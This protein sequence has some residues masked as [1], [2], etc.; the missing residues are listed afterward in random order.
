MM[1]KEDAVRGRCQVLATSMA[2]AV[3]LALLLPAA[4]GAQFGKNKIQYREFDWKIYHSPHFDVYYYEEEEHLLQKVV[5]FAESAYDHLS[6]EFDYQIKQP[7]P[8]IFYETHSAFEQNNI[9]MNFIPEGIGAFASPVR[10]RMVLPVDLPDPQLMELILHELTH[11]FQYNILCGASAGK[12]VAS[13]PPQWFME[14]M[15]SYMAKDESARDRMYLRD[16]V[17]NDRIPAVTS[18]QVSGFFAYRFGHAVFDFIEEKYGKEAFRDFMV[19]MRNTIG[20]R[21]GRAVERTFRMDP[22]D[23]DGEFRRWLRKKYLPELL[24]TGEPADFGR[25]FRTGRGVGSAELSPAASPSGDLVAAFSTSK[26]DI[27]VVLFDARERELLRN[28][29]KG[30]SA[31]YQ[32]FV[33]QDLAVARRGGHDL[34]FSPDGN[35]LAFFARQDRGRK[36]VLI[37]VLKGKIMRSLPMEVEQQ[38]GLAWSPDGSRIAFGGHQDGRFD[39]FEVDVA[40]GAVANLTSDGVYDQ[41]PTYSP[42]GKSMVFSSV[43]GGYAKLFRIDRANPGERFQLTQGESNETDAIYSPDGTQI[44]FTSDRSGADNI[45]GLELESGQITQYTNSVTGCSQPAVLARPDG[46]EELVYT[47]Y[48]KGRFDL[49]RLDIKDPITEPILIADAAEPD[50]KAIRADEL[51]RFEPTIEVA[52]D[53]A[54]KDKYGGFKLF[55]EDAGGTMGVSDDQTFIAQAY[56]SFTDYLGDKRILGVFQ[57]I[58]S[59]QNFNIIYTDLSR[60]WQWQVHLFD[61]R[62]FFLSRDAFGQIRRG[63]SALSQTGVIASIIYPINTNHRVEV[64][65][66]YQVR[67]ID[68]QSSVAVP[69][70]DFDLPG[71]FE[72]VP[73]LRELEPFFPPGLNDE[74]LLA[75]IGNTFFPSGFVAVP[76]IT[77]REDDYPLIQAAL[78]GDSAVFAPWGGVTGR[79]WRLGFDWAPD[80]ESSGTLTSTLSVDF[81]QYLTLT[82]RSNIAVRFVGLVREGNFATP[83]FFGGLDTLRGFEFRGFFANF[84]LRFPLIDLLATPI[85]NFQ[86]VRALFFL[87]VGGAWFD[88][89]QEFDFWDSE[90]SR[91]G[92]G[93]SSYGFGLSFRLLGV[94]WNFDYAKRWDLKETEDGGYRSSFWI[95]R[96]F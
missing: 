20:A 10:N 58:E 25:P 63:T 3:V 29:T 34:V 94:D 54:S 84:E 67:D 96:R 8:M 35:D 44:Y 6:Q 42:D 93:L 45:Y 7:T 1:R 9:I 86:G 12:C 49:Y 74:Q 90:N 81:R 69:F 52:I 73:E 27:D 56:M 5:S 19:E 89:F 30:W 55:I 83:F 76:I 61:D 85:I 72:A 41:S 22:E 51:P 24:E 53:D 75:F 26:G 16:A 92:D 36:L 40:S 80:T 32:Y 14:G 68:F 21:V 82:R 47:A 31:D 78:V 33:V 28:L 39:I 60:R 4:S 71:L 66:G 18:S 59:F 87:D 70:S 48:W 23:F 13:A 91:L 88:E 11:I 17:V 2:F 37:D 43:V 79:R 62:D 77:P 50:V 57:S 64:G 38:V 15:A 65:A 46:T 95:G